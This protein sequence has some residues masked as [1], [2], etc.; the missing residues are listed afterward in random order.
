MG[1]PVI[2]EGGGEIVISGMRELALALD[3]FPDK[4][5]KKALDKVLKRG[6]RYIVNVAKNL[7]PVRSGKLRRSI[8]VTLVRK[9]GQLIARVIAGRRVKKDDPYYA[10]MVEAGTKPHEI[11]PRGKKSLFLAGL[12]SEVVKHP[13]SE[14]HPFLG[15]ALEQG[16]ETALEL[17]KD[18]LAAQV[19]QLS[20]I[21]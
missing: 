13:G 2:T 5:Q 6:G 4:L 10:W 3:A 12:F 21:G 17:M 8:R 11:R 7:V 1:V 9:N 19:E 16:A 18:E 14:A 15:P 20:E